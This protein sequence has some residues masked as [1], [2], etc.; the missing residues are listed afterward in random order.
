MRRCRQSLIVLAL[1][2]LLVTGVAAAQQPRRFDVRVTVT[3]ISERAGKIDPG[4]RRLD[5]HLRKKFRYKSLRVIEQRRLALQLDEVGSVR[6]PN[7]RM[8]RVRPLN[9]G[10]RGLLMAVGWEDAMQMDMHAP[11]NHLMVI[12]G[13]AY[14][15]GQLVISI[16]PRY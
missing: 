5:Q 12:G 10:D 15:D 8:F 3:H 11:S 7:G 2:A 4:A 16:E 14:Q 1:G 9:L 13:P 6:L